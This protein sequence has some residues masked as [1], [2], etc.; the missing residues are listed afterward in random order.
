MGTVTHNRFIG[1]R[2]AILPPH[3]E[4]S[5]LAI[6]EDRLPS[7]SNLVCEDLLEHNETV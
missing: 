1:P 4:T 5:N 6:Q 2:T 7:I 3:L